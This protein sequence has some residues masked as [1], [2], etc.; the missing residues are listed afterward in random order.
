M[1]EK[2][3][4]ARGEGFGAAPE[5]FHAFMIEKR[6][7]RGE[8]YGAAREVFQAFIIEKRSALGEGWC[9]IVSIARVAMQTSGLTSG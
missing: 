6:S 2:R 8:G 5:L 4:A 3:S 1:I 9:S 7:A